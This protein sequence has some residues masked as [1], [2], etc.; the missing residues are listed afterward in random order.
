M[1]NGGIKCFQI[2]ILEWSVCSDSDR[3]GQ[4]PFILRISSGE[5]ERL[6]HAETV[7]SP[8]GWL[9]LEQEIVIECRIIT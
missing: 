5:N 6:I 7:F 8:R 4:Y 1:K 2:N 3:A 9:D